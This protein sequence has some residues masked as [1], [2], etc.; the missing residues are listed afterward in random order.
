MENRQTPPVEDVHII[1]SGLVLEMHPLHGMMVLNEQWQEV[2]HFDD[3]EWGHGASGMLFAYGNPIAERPVD[4]KIVEIIRSAR[5]KDA[6]ANLQAH[7]K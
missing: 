5:N 7:N 6:E 3:V 4:Q 2:A 1:A